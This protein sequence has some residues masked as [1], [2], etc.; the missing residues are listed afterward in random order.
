[1]TENHDY[2]A[3]SWQEKLAGAELGAR[4]HIVAV[5]MAFVTWEYASAGA[6]GA[7]GAIGFGIISGSLFLSGTLAYIA[8]RKEGPSE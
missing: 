7:G 2:H 5:I 3:R 8:R 1:M 4:L 6:S